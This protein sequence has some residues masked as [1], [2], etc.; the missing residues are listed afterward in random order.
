MTLQHSPLNRQ[1]SRHLWT[2][3][4]VSVA[5]FFVGISFTGIAAAQSADIASDAEV[6]PN[7]T[8]E[9]IFTPTNEANQLS[10]SGEVAGWTV[11]EMTPNN[12]LTSPSNLPTESVAGDNWA[13]VGE[14]TDGDWR[15][16]VSPPDAATVGESYTFN[17]DEQDGQANQV[18]TDTLT[19]DI[20]EASGGN[21]GSTNE[22]SS[23]NGTIISD[24]EVAPNGSTELIFTPNDNANQLSVSGEIAGWT[25]EQMS[26]NSAFTSPS[27]L[28]TKSSSGDNWGTVG[29]YNDGEW[30]VTV[31]PPDTADPGDTYKLEAQ[32]LDGQNNQVAVESFT[33][34]I[35]ETTP[36][37][38]W[39]EQRAISADQYRA[40]DTDE[41][42]TLNGNEI[43]TG[44][45]TYISNLPSGEVNGVA[46]RGDDIRELVNGYINNELI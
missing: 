5:I 38:D 45:S 19:V 40:F 33:I 23:N 36:V 39:V 25:V 20:V 13:T 14:Y 34:T 32:E 31:S 9:L 46:F 6:S 16:T 43:R 17:I 12:P 15:V 42:S 28:P 41:S 11:E 18:A 27:D 1:L 4:V 24:A 26:P 30:R 3:L 29:A 37:P 10:V 35:S 2:A 7:G 8:V 44:V 22:S 21:D